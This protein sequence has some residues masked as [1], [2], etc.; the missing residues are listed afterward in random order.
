MKSGILPLGWWWPG[1]AAAGFLA[2]AGLRHSE[3]AALSEQNRLLA[4]SL[5]ETTK[6]AE[7][8]VNRLTN[9]AAEGDEEL[10]QLRRESADLPRLRNEIRQLRRQVEELDR[11]QAENE[12]LR[13]PAPAANEALPIANAGLATPATAI[14]TFL[15][16]LR[17]AD[18]D[19]LLMCLEL[20]AGLAVSGPDFVRPLLAHPL[21]VGES[22]QMQ[23][24]PTD[25]PD[26]E[27]H[28]LVRLAAGGQVE[29]LTLRHSATGWRIVFPA[30]GAGA[31]IN[32]PGAAAPR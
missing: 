17:Q 20:P 19:R 28:C 16:A 22:F 4:A 29:T 21:P 8:W 12:R 24:L 2:A 27:A 30:G 23:N 32:A 1:L 18:A 25:E 26:K 31:G 15:W 6:P 9:A 13:S 10:A 3:V 7:P 5:T 11:L 14:Q